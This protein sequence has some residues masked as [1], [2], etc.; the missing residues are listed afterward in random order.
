MP[1]SGGVREG[2]GRLRS[3]VD[4]QI[5]SPSFGKEET[6]RR[7]GRLGRRTEGRTRRGTPAEG[8]SRRGRRTR[9]RTPTPRPE[10]PETDGSSWNGRGV[11]RTVGPSPRLPC[12]RRTDRDGET[13]RRRG[14]RDPAAGGPRTPTS[15]QTTRPGTGRRNTTRPLPG[16]LPLF[17]VGVGTSGGRSPTSVRAPWGT[18]RPESMSRAVL[19]LR[20]PGILRGDPGGSEQSLYLLLPERP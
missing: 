15:V 20:R 7:V 16:T 5:P 8:P 12:R 1:V 13:A 19:R 9:T 10:G 11:L 2:R 17:G 14:R 18:T 3:P 6:L 4:R